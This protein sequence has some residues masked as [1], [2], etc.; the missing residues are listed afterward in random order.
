MQ[1]CPYRECPFGKIAIGGFRLESVEST[2]ATPESDARFILKVL[3]LDKDVALAVDQVVGKGT[4]PLTSYFF[5][6]RNDAWEQLKA[7]IES[8]SWITDEESVELLN[9]ATEI[10][11]YWQEEGKTKPMTEAQKKFPEVAFTGSS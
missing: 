4:S 8:K 11:N 1:L 7:E 9:K 5:W 2:A 6:P 3:W 10:I